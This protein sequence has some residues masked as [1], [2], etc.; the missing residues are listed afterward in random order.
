MKYRK[1][2]AGLLLVSS[3]V[4]AG[5]IS[6]DNYPIQKIAEQLDK[7]ATTNP[8]EKVYLQFDKPYYAVGDDIWFKAYITIGS[9]HRLSGLS[10]VLNVELIDD[11]DSV[12]QHLKLRIISG[13]T[14]G[15]F[16][17]SDTLAEGNYRI[18]AYTNYMRNAGEDYFFDKTI[19]IVNVATNKVFTKSDYTYSTENGQQKVT[20][21][22]N[23]SDINGTPYANKEVKYSVVLDVKTVLK[24]KGV[25][26]DKGNISISFINPQPGALHSGRIITTLK[27]IAGKDEVTKEVLI[28]AATA[29]VDVQFFP[30]SGSLVNGINSKVAFKAVG[31]DG[32]GADI[33]GIITDEQDNKITDFSTTH[34]GMGTFMLEPQAGKTYKARITYADGS[35]GAVSLPQ[36]VDKGYVLSIDNTDSAYIK[37]KITTSRAM[38][39]DNPDDTL[40]LV[41]QEGGE[42][43]F[44]ARSRP[45]SASFTASITK[46]RFHSGIVQFT[47][48]SSKGE[49]LNERL[50][51]IQNPDLLKL[52]IK[53][54][55]QTYAPQEKVRLNLNAQNGDSKPV[56]GSFSVAV[57]DETKVPFDEASESTILSNLLL[58]SDLKGYVEKPNY[59]FTS[60]SD[61][62]RADLDALMLTQGYRR[63]EWKQVLNDNVP[64]LV[65]RPEKTFQISG[66]ITTLGDKPL[67]HAKVT[68]LSTHAGMFYADTVTDG[69]GRFEFKNLVFKDSIKFVIQ[70]RTE[71][72]RKNVKIDLDDYKGQLVTGNKNAP[73]MQVSVSSGLSAYL[74]SSRS[75]YSEQIKY[76]LGNHSIA[77]KEV[78][79]TAE[80]HVVKY[81]DNLNGPGNADQVLTGDQVPQG[82]ITVE[83]CL[84]GRLVGVIFQNGVPY[85]TRG[86]AMKVMV[87]GISLSG[88]DLNSVNME[89]VQTVEVLRSS[90]YVSIYG[91]EAGPGGLIILTMKRGDDANS[92]LTRPA[93]GILVYAPI[94]YAKIRRFYSPQYDDP[95]TNIEVAN[96]RSTIYWDPNIIT[97]KDG[98]ASFEYFNAGSKGTYRVIVEGIDGDG[99]IGRQVFRYKVE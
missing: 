21:T 28:R 11:R 10:G 98:N 91:S 74:Q 49:P 94:G 87:D 65:Y 22:I 85:S 67:A 24:G 60:V 42:I 54:T 73:D 15:D 39:Q 81:S 52:D 51:F 36:A 99:N 43:L 35:E 78:V 83:M 96:Q 50:V 93:P 44:A 95:K 37:L 32:L 2:V 57:V 86:G 1:I 27:P 77:L 66:H 14:W 48:F 62:S 69:Q 29:N 4:I 5:F 20:A 97:G 19:S 3:L 70:A 40:N 8:I 61:K 68:L 55:K 84:E 72:D 90:F 58:T 38:L 82:C 23:Y 13:L 6:A 17:L 46:S 33:K 92:Y 18:R 53:S 80:K 9:R 7:W 63:F 47:L 56:V 88:S 75:L 30:E 16:S 31:A 26:D 79:I 59:Y 64:P 41:A 25:T 71:K 76:G 89:E 34:A 45:G 12:K